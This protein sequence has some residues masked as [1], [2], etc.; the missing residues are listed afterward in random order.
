MAQSCCPPRPPA[1]CSSPVYVVGP[2]PG[3]RPDPGPGPG[4]GL[5]PGPSRSLGLGPN[6]VIDSGS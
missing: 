4:H 1:H 3:T 6:P 5:S 2:A